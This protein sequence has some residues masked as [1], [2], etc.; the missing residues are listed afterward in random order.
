MKTVSLFLALTSFVLCASAQSSEDTK[1]RKVIGSLCSTNWDGS[2]GTCCKNNNNGA[3]VTVNNFPDCFGYVYT[4]SSSITSLF[5]Y[6][7]LPFS[8]KTM[9]R[10]FSV[11]G[12][13]NIPAGSPFSSLSDLKSFFFLPQLFE[14][15]F[16]TWDLGGN[17]IRGLFSGAFE[18]L[19]NL[20]YFFRLRFK[21]VFIPFTLRTRFI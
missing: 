9:Y 1:L 18:G 14:G 6:K 17:E 11:T 12:L 7:F 4:S 13:T 15:V 10:D 19:S 20:E 2:F 21:S 16:F 8:Q 5:V 3:Y